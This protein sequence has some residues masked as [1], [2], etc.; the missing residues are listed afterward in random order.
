MLERKEDALDERETA[1]AK[2]KREAETL[3]S[4]VE[5]L[6][7]EA[8]QE[9]VRVAALSKEE[10][11]TIIMDEAKQEALHDAA[12]LQKEIEQKA[13]LEADK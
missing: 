6:Y 3:E 4:K 1:L 8:R 11:R 13:K 2:R 5:E 9:L 12:L 10:A 7:E